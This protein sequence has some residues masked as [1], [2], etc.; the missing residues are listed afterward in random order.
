MNLMAELE[1]KVKSPEPRHTQQAATV[2]PPAAKAPV[3]AAPVRIAQVP[4]AAALLETGCP[5][6]SRDSRQPAAAMANPVTL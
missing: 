5:C 6:D 2:A 4:T 1:D 3:S